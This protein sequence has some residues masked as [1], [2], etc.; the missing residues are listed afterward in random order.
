MPLSNGATFAGFKIVGL[1]RSGGM[2]EVIWPN[3]RDFRGRTPSSFC[4]RNGRLTRS[5]GAG[6]VGRPTWRQRCGIPISWG[7]MHD[8]GEDDGQLRISMDF[9]GSLNAAQLLADRYPAAC[10]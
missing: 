2:G 6:S 10:P 4:P 5:T 8:R 9:V 1:L 7:C 3:I